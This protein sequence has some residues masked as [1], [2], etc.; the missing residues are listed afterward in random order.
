MPF[1][2]YTWNNTKRLLILLSDSLDDIMQMCPVRSGEFKEPAND[3]VLFR[4]S[5]KS[6]AVSITD[7]SI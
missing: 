6:A 1:F 2:T 7:S 3:L 5:V 4:Q